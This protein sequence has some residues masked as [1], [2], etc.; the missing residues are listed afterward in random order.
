MTSSKNG[1]AVAGSLIVDQHFAIDNYPDKSNLTKIRGTDRTLGG[2]G[3]MICQLSKMDPDLPVR[4]SAILGEHS[5]GRFVR[6]TLSAFPNVELKNI[7]YGD[8]TPATIVM[9]ALDDNTRTFFF[10]GAG[11]DDYDYDNVDWDLI[12]S[13]IFHL[14]YLLLMKNIDSPDPEYGTGAAKILHEARRRGMITSIDMVSAIGMEG[15][16]DIVKASL[17][18]TDI[19]T[20]NELEAELVTGISINRKAVIDEEAAFKAL[21][22]LK[23]YGVS[24][25]A[26]IHSS[27]MGFGL[28]CETGETISLRSLKLPEGFIK[29]TTGAGDAYCS[30]ILLGAIRDM[31]LRD[32]MKVAT[33][34][35][36]CSLSAVN[37]YDGLRPFEEVL[38]LYEESKF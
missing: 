3:N 6:E 31:E 10:N 32:A 33:G 14:E 23:E 15:A 22:L 21:S 25:W 16:A 8:S 28:D 18:Y 12:D 35:A 7:T 13:R 24:K 4:V 29:G 9:D 26:V 38:K 30:G 20:I 37:G 5:N 2:T 1:I 17:K 27:S 19:C 36:A 34:S 11:S